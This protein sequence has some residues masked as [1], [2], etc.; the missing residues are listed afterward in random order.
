MAVEWWVIQCNWQ[1]RGTH[2]EENTLTDWLVRKEKRE[3]L[4]VTA[5]LLLLLL[6][7]LLVLQVSRRGWLAYSSDDCVHRE[8]MMLLEE[9]NE[10][11]NRLKGERKCWQE[12]D[13][14]GEG[15]GEGAG[16]HLWQVCTWPRE[17]KRASSS[18]GNL[19]QE[20]TKKQYGCR[21]DRRT[22]QQ[23]SP[24]KTD[25]WD[26]EMNI[27]IFSC[28]SLVTLPGNT[29]QSLLLWYF[30]HSMITMIPIL[31]LGFFLSFFS[32]T[33]SHSFDGK[34]TRVYYFARC[35]LLFSQVNCDISDCD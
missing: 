28:S 7:L 31:L 19:F 16:M 6:L 1:G 10:N 26:G 21:A 12:E 22:G 34:Q 9:T 5:C 11:D 23:S 24:H 18:R 13:D 14:E 30:F 2:A 4:R 33:H 25:A 3:Q 32:L 15:E 8:T 20:A 35:I 29:S 17:M 27:C